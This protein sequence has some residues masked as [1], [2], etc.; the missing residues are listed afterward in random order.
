MATQQEVIYNFMQSLDNTT[1][2]GAAAVNE[3][4]RASSDFKNFKAVKKQFMNDLRSAKNWQTFLV[5]KCGIILDNADTGAISGSD[6][7]GT[8]KTAAT[9]IP[10]KGKAKYPSGTSFTVNG[11]TI[12]GI[13]DKSK[14]TSDQQYIVRGLYSWWIRDSLALIEESYGLTFDG[15][16]N[17]RLRLKFFDDETS[18]T[19][20]YVSYD[21]ENLE[22]FEDRELAVNMVMFKNMKSSDR[23]GTTATYNLDRTLVHELVHGLM[24]PNLKYF[25]D[26]PIFLAE[27]GTAELIHGVDDERYNQI[28]SC[29]QDP[30]TLNKV[31]DSTFTESVIE[32]YSGGYVFMRYFAKQAA[33]DTSFDYDTYRKTVSTDSNGGF[34][35][36]YWN[37]V[38]MKGGAGEDT[39]TNSGSKVY[40]TAGAKADIVKNYSAKV[41]INGGSGKDTITNNGA[42]VSIM[43][44]KGNDSV[45]SYGKK[46]TID[47][48]AGKDSIANFGAK[49]SVSGGAGADNI[50]NGVSYYETLNVVSSTIFET[51]TFVADDE[52]VVVGMGN[53]T[54]NAYLADLTGGNS[55]SIFGGAG[56]DSL[57]NYATKAQLFGEDDDD[58]ITNY[59]L[60]AKVYGD[61]GDDYIFNGMA[62]VEV[63]MPGIDKKGI[64]NVSGYGA[65]LAGGKGNDSIENEANSAIIYGDGGADSIVNS[66]SDVSVYGGAGA[67][68]FYNMGDSSQLFGESGKD[69]IMN[70]GDFSYLSGGNNNDT[71][72]SCGEADSLDGGTGKDYLYNEGVNAYLFGGASND[73]IHNEG[74]HATIAGGEGND[75]IT[76][77]GGKYTVYQF[78]AGDGKDTVTGF[79]DG[80][81]IQITSGSYKSSKSGSDVVVKV[82]SSKLTLKDAVNK[83]INF[84]NAKGKTTT[85][86]YSAKVSPMWFADDNNFSTTDNLNSLVE[87][88]SYSAVELNYSSDL[89][90]DE[91]KNNFITSGG[92]NS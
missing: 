77:N 88:K 63:E 68:S 46:V 74:D 72:Y 73:T 17:S 82:G 86:T 10:S 26:L 27:G 22:A 42:Q 81:T 70:F 19:L 69:E 24:A 20:A 2:K 57:T 45:E 90:S 16:N 47:G 89:T 25:N 30:D 5:E 43:G 53:S 6:A 15:A 79:N 65:Q 78:G 49:S 40:I 34:I 36:N 21:P 60:R 51:G 54:M 18:S 52:I 62:T 67:D 75:S 84:I 91:N 11:L 92:T 64:A 33:A 28:I 80:E 61:A 9:V 29:V 8:E 59:G 1:L 7:G 12:Y 55:S 83:Q 39:I 56:E 71:I 32:A 41:S 48:G 3:A 35:T 85:K 44:G 66:G 23:H 58:L 14:L 4:I 13:P 31:L 38:T 37:T 87:N 50:L 76:N